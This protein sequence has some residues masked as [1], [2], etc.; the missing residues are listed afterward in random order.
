MCSSDLTPIFSVTR[1]YGV[2]AKTGQHTSGAGDRDR[3]GY[4]LSPRMKGVLTP[5]PDKSS[6]TYWH[7]NYDTPLELIFQ[8][9]E[10]VLGL[11]TYRYEAQFVTDQTKE[12]SGLPEVGVTRG[13]NLEGTLTVWI[14]PISGRRVKYQDRATAYFYDLETNK[15]LFP[16]NSFRNETATV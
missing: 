12:L 4:L 13:V 3:E 9:E 7:V 5:V 15:R 10:T 11:P 8:A 14:E 2:D 1:L 16:W 6:F